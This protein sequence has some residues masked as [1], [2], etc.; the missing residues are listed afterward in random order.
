MRKLSG[1]LEARPVSTWSAGAASS[2]MIVSI[3]V[4]GQM[5]AKAVLPSLE[6]SHTMTT[7]SAASTRAAL[8][9]AS[10]SCWA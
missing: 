2:V 8:T 10:P 9:A 1:L 4:L 5:R 3:L 6:L 7:C